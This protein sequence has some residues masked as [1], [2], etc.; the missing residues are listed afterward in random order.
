M[1]KY[2]VS[3]IMHYV[4]VMFTVSKLICLSLDRDDMRPIWLGLEEVV[5]KGRHRWQEDMSQVTWTKWKKGCI[6]LSTGRWFFWNFIIRIF[7]KIIL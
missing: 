2:F 6:F 7:I 4:A 1:W 5:G 3:F